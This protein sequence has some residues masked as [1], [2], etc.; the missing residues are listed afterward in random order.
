MD[1]GFNDGHDLPSMTP[2]TSCAEEHPRLLSLLAGVLTRGDVFL[3]VGA[4]I[5]YFSVPIASL[6]GAEGQVVAFEPAADSAR[7]LRMKA[8]DL[9]LLPRIS[10]HEMALGSE[11]Q[12]AVLRGDPEYPDDSTKRSLVIDGPAVGEVRVRSFDGLVASGEVILP[13]GI[14]AVKIDVEGAEMDVLAGMRGSL[15]RYRP[16]MV[17]AETI[18]GHLRRAGSTVADVHAFMRTLD[19][20]ALEG[21][22]IGKRLELNAVFVP[23]KARD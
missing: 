10:I 1:M 12:S 16:R 4:N 3:D 7:A 15:D 18:Q 9:G 13:K 20:V 14:Q 17:V 6:V 23:P 5:G 2:A 22:R 11:D 19:Y 8:R 21:A